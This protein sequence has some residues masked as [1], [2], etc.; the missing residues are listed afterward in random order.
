MI[1]EQHLST[2]PVREK[3][4][5]GIAMSLANDAAADTIPGMM[6]NM[7]IQHHIDPKLTSYQFHGR[8]TEMVNH[9]LTARVTDA[10]ESMETRGRMI[11][12]RNGGL[13]GARMAGARLQA[14]TRTANYNPFKPFTFLPTPRPNHT[15]I[16]EPSETEVEAEQRGGLTS[17]L[18]SACRRFGYKTLEIDRLSFRHDFDHNELTLIERGNEFWFS[19]DGSYSGPMYIDTAHDGSITLYEANITCGHPSTVQKW[20]WFKI[21][22]PLIASRGRPREFGGV[23]NSVVTFAIPTANIEKVKEK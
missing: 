9:E 15:M 12:H 21:S 14:V 13:P 18:E 20:T 16:V 17:W 10:Y 5:K 8:G 2:L 4:R 23:P 22:K 7:D 6:E 3:L 1:S 11:Q 19:P